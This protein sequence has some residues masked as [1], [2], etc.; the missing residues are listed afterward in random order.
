VNEEDELAEALKDPAVVKSGEEFFETFKIITEGS[1]VANSSIE[2]FALCAEA[3]ARMKDATERGKLDRHGKIREEKP[4]T[5]RRA[6]IEH[7]RKKNEDS[8]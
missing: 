1:P 7:T 4:P 8:D 2:A 3:F 5:G 6:A